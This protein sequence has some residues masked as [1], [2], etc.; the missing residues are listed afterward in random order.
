[1]LTAFAPPHLQELFLDHLIPTVQ[2]LALSALNAGEWRKA[3]APA[4]GVLQFVLLED[5]WLTDQLVHLSQ[6]VL[7]RTF[8]CTLSEVWKALLAQSDEDLGIEEPDGL[9]AG[10]YRS[11]LIAVLEEWEEE[12]NLILTQR[13]DSFFRRIGQDVPRLRILSL[14]GSSGE[15]SSED[16]APDKE[17]ETQPRTPLKT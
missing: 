10:T 7:F 14:P 12:T 1:M 15:S 6:P 16:E 9:F 11:R 17:Q 8:F 4:L 13:F 5:C 2:Q 3:L